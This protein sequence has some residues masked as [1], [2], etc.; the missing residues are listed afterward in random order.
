MGYV[1]GNVQGWGNREASAVV[2][3]GDKGGLHTRMQ[4]VRPTGQGA[5]RRKSR[6]KWEVAL[7]AGALTPAGVGRGPTVCHGHQD[8][9]PGGRGTWAPF[10]SFF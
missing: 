10:L 3:V 7:Q 4:E 1:A 5:W 6:G 9:E 8:E 2:Q